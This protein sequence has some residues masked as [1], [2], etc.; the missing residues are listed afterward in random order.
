[1]KDICSEMEVNFLDSRVFFGKLVMREAG[2]LVKDGEIS[3]YGSI[4]LFNKYTEA[5]KKF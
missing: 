4:D 3:E 1:M 5:T 2:C